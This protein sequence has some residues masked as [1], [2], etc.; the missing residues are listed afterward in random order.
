MLRARE[1][2]RHPPAES[3]RAPPTTVR[4]YFP[5]TDLELWTTE[6]TLTNAS[7]YF[8]TLFASGFAESIGTHSKRRRTEGGAPTATA[9]VEGELEFEDSD[10]EADE[11]YVEEK[12]PAA[13]PGDMVYREVSITSA[14]YSTYAAL[15]LWLS[16]GNV[17]FAPLRSRYRFGNWVEEEEKSSSRKDDLFGFYKAHPNRA[18]PSSPK[19][20]FRLA[21][22]LD[23]PTLKALAL[24][25]YKSMLSNNFVAAELVCDVLGAYEELRAAAVD[26]VAKGDWGQV[27]KSAAMQQV[28]KDIDGDDSMKLRYAGVVSELMKK[29]VI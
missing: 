28:L 1:E 18:I 7:P 2:L 22:F 11:I 17:D 14:T 4:L 6:Q 13:D 10:D 5:N 21:H 15:L 3:L 20:L 9:A 23:M 16:S 19:S 24:A 29:G 12:R 27:R 25:S 26:F 8:A